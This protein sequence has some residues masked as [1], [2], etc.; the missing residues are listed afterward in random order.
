VWTAVGAGTTAPTNTISIF[1]RQFAFASASAANGSQL[2]IGV[3]GSCDVFINR[4]YVGS[5]VRATLPINGS[6]A[7]PMY[8]PTG[9]TTSAVNVTLRCA[10]SMF[11]T[12]SNPAGLIAALVSSGGMALGWTN[13]TWVARVET[14]APYDARVAVGTY[15]ECVADKPV[16]ICLYYDAPWWH[17]FV[18]T[19]TGRTRHAPLPTVYASW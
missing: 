12:A 1:T 18:S 2:L 9:A 17:L 8:I 4:V 10:N 3:D 15:C 5:T 19:L 7:T 6:G 14:T 13:A 11:P 16:R